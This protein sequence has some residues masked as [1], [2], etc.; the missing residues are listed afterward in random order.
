MLQKCYNLRYTKFI[1]D[2]DIKFHPIVVNANQYPVVKA[3]C[4]G[5]VQK[6]VGTRLRQI[7]TTCKDTMPSSGKKKP[8]K[9]VSFLTHD[10]INRL[11]NYYGLAVRRSTNTSVHEMRKAIALFH[12]S[13]ANLIDGQHQFCP[14]RSDSLCKYQA[15]EI[16]GTNNYAEKDGPPIPVK[17]NLSSQCLGNLANLA[18]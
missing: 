10:L 6:R 7:K 15:D 4:V 9:L 5:H 14:S 11:Q 16:N 8:R 17:K 13:Q 18:Y 12:C 2:G 3:E 1:G